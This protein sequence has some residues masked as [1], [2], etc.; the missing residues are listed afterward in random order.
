MTIKVRGAHSQLRCLRAS[1]RW[2]LLAVFATQPCDG[3]TT[4]DL[5]RAV[6]YSVVRTSPM[7]STAQ[8]ISSLV[9]VSGGATRITVS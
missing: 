3:A 4:C 5:H 1:S 8:S 7:H 2:M 6:R 9:M